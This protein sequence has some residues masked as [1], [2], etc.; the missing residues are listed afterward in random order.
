MILVCA[1]IIGP[2]FTRF[3]LAQYFAAPQFWEFLLNIIG[4]NYSS[5]P[6]TFTGT[7]SPTVNG[8]LWTLGYEMV[9]YAFVALLLVTRQ[10]NAPI[11]ITALAVFATIISFYV[12]YNGINANPHNFYES[13]TLHILLGRES[14]IMMTFICGIIAYQLK[15]IIPYSKWI[16]LVC[17]A[18]C[19]TAAVTLNIKL[20]NEIL[21]RI[22]LLPAL[23]Y[24][25]IFIGMSDIK[26]PA[27]LRK[28]DLSYGIYLYH[29]P[30]MHLVIA[31]FPAL[32]I[33]TL[34]GA[35][36]TYL[37]GLPFHRYFS[38]YFME[39]G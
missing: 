4:Q 5:L 1:L 14:Q 26:Y 9:C 36:F 15:N 21:L 23:T 8:A 28:N 35:F 10:L 11:K 34:Y 12:E 22:I 3:S 13:K 24:I 2:V 27:F 6:G 7:A 29:D 33:A 17:V 31:L 19:I 39:S 20:H 30:V 18:I 32:G 37:A 16:F 38:L 25:T